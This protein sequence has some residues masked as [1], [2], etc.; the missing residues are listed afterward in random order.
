MR[1]GLRRKRWYFGVLVG[2][3]FLLT[4]FFWSRDSCNNAYSSMWISSRSG[5]GSQEIDWSC[6]GIPGYDGA[7]GECTLEVRWIPRTDKHERGP[8]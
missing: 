2:L 3:V 6:E 1:L 4:E 5:Q 8:P 7:D